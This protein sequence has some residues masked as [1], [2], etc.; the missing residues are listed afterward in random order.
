M[1]QLTKQIA[2]LICNV[3]PTN[4]SQKCRLVLVYKTTT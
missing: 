4:Y 1:A 2:A 3:S